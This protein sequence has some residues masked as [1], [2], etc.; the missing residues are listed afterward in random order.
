MKYFGILFIFLTLIDSIFCS[1]IEQKIES[2]IDDTYSEII[3]QKIESRADDQD[4]EIIE[5]NALVCTLDSGMVTFNY[6][7]DKF[8]EYAKKNNKNISMNLTIISNTNSTYYLGSLGYMI[9][10]LLKKETSKYDLFFFDNTY[11]S[12]YGPYLLDLTDLIPKEH[13]DMYD[14]QIIS[15]IGR[16]KNKL[17]AL[18][19]LLFIFYNNY[20]KCVKKFFF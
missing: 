13:I 3:E 5:L 8:N 4:S 16:Y 9:E 1:V 19:S 15:Q 7:R 11:T 17:V 20:N 18:V 10:N 6:Y 2:K 12:D 14:E